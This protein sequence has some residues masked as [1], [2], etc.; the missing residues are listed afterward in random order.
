LSLALFVGSLALAFW[1]GLGAYPLSKVILASATSLQTV[2]ILMIVWLIMVMSKIMKEAG[3]MER[4]V[5]SFSRLSGDPRTVGS[6]MTALIGLLPM[7]GG[8]LFSAPMVDASLA[9]LPVNKEQKTIINYWFRHLWEYWW[10]IYPGVILALALLKVETWIYISTMAPVTVISVLAGT[11][12]IL[13]PIRLAQQEAKN[14][15]SWKAFGRFLK[16]IL[17]ILI[18]IFFI[19]FQAALTE[20]FEMFGVRFAMPGALSILPGLVAAL[21]WVAVSNHLPAYRIR[22]SLMDQGSI[23]ILLLIVAIM[24]FQGVLKESQAALQI[25][26]ELLAYGI[27]VSLVI[28]ILPFIAGFITG[29]A[30]GFVGTSFPLIIPMFPESNLLGYLSSAAL[31]FTFGFMGMMLSPV[32][33]CFLVTKDYYGASLIKS[34]R[35]LLLP[36][37]S[38][39]GIVA[40]VYFLIQ[41]L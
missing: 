31:A 28:M 14:H 20:I 6:V 32:H 36:A 8:A 3:Q 12:F 21:V 15:V 7:P 27:P 39:M 22:A 35:Y 11:L 37:R 41:A 9:A 18:I 5:S 1:M 29:I 26:S 4:L 2:G 40:A 34:Y 16:E 33:L 38:V 10:P 30:V 23:S 19:V 24:I 13:R 25:R 17:P